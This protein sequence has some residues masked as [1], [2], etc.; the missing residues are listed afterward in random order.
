MSA[1]RLPGPED[2]V[3]PGPKSRAEE[4]LR[5][6]KS[7]AAWL[8]RARGRVMI[9][10]AL[11]AAG[12]FLTVAAVLLDVRQ[13]AWDRVRDASANLT[14]A[15]ERDLSSEIRAIDLTLRAVVGLMARTGFEHS[16]ADLREGLVLERLS[17]SRYLDAVV[18]LDEHGDAMFDTRQHILPTTVNFSEQDVFAAHR[19]RPDVGLFISAPYPSR[20]VDRLW[21]IGVSRRLSYPNGNFAGVVLA[22]V[23]VQDLQAAF[24]GMRLGSRGTMTLI[25]EDGVV[26]A[27]NPADARLLGRDLG[28]AGPVRQ[29]QLA[30]S[31]QFLAVAAIDGVERFYTYR[32]LDGAPLIFNVALA[33]S[34]I[35]DSWWRKAA[36][37]SGLTGILVI[38]MLTMVIR[39]HRELARRK[40]AELATRRSETSFRLLA[41]NSSD[42]VSHIDLVG[43][44]LYVSPAAAEIFGRPLEELM[45]RAALDDVAPE[46]RTFVQN[47]FRRLWRG[48]RTITFEARILRPDGEQVWI[49]ASARPLLNDATGKPEGYVT[50]ARDVTDRKL[51]EARLTALA[52]TDALTDLANRR[53]FDEALDRE[54]HRARRNEA[55]LSLLLIDADRFKLFNDS[56]GHLAGD[57]C[58]QRLADAAAEIGRRPA[59]V[60]ARYGGEEF[61]ILLPETGA[62]DAGLLAEGLRAH[63]ETLTLPHEANPPAG[64][65]TVSIGVATA[66]PWSAPDC[67]PVALVAA[68]DASLYRAKQSGRN[69]VVAAPDTVPMGSVR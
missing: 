40:D 2:T 14:L 67:T 8:A 45:G 23:Q 48:E 22:A 12:V 30:R 10:G 4:S 20:L 64:V 62:A 55:P 9:T 33:V 7:I 41:E 46:D 28:S 54:W 51:A 24:E 49:E 56:Y 15:V 57:A 11:L 68:A 5:S 26:L 53:V 61:A 31:G 42:M 34:D 32:H 3:A 6:I 52:R 21:T 16:S 18:I 58:L 50:V 36:L 60:V 25:R 1:G 63:I 37:I 65:V 29:M 19:D 44:R 66:C 35:Y 17:S 13:D 47:S 27:R 59:D 43:R 38:A 69:R 39:L